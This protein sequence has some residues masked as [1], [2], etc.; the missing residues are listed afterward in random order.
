MCTPEIV[1]FDVANFLL[2]HVDHRTRELDPFLV[3]ETMHIYMLST[4]T[5]SALR[6]L[7]LPFGVFDARKLLQTADSMKWKNPPT[8]FDSYAIVSEFYRRARKLRDP[9]LL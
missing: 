1:G 8:F 4:K 6:L 7:T 9:P 2:P 5:R 3:R